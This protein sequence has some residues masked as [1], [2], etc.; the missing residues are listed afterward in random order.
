MTFEQYRQ[1][2]ECTLSPY[3]AHHS[4]CVAQEAVRL[5]RRYGADVQKA[6][7]AG[8]LHDSTKELPPEEQLQ[9]IEEFGI[10]LSQVE[11][12]SPKLLHAISGMAAAQTRFGV[13]DGEIL[14]AIRYHTTARAGMTLLEKVVCLADYI[15]ADRSYDGVE[16]LRESAYRDLDG[17]LI[18]CL[19]FT[20]GELSQKQSLIHPDTVEAYNSLI[21]SRG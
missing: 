6:Q 1:E 4:V 14:G 5:A 3:R 18:E 15:S 11:K 7:T 2:I 21:L 17:T 12:R 9:M 19:A 16:K 20:I 8:I 13:S 10:I